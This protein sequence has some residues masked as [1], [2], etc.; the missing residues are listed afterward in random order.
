MGNQKSKFKPQFT[1]SWQ[2]KNI[3]HAGQAKKKAEPIA[4]EVDKASGP[5]R[6]CFNCNSP[7]HIARHCPEKINVSKNKSYTIAI[8]GG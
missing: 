5:L 7:K 1:S 3:E 8:F 6:R 2:G 4:S